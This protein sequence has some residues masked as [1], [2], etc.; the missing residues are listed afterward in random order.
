[1]TRNPALATLSFA[2]R[3]Q[4]VAGYLGQL[5]LL[6]SALTLLPLAVALVDAE[7]R[8][9]IGLAAASL[10]LGVF[11][12]VA[13][14]VDAAVRIQANEALAVTA[15]SYLLTA[16]VMALPMAAQGLAP[17]DALFESVSA[18]TTTG[19][20]T[21]TASE[22]MPRSLL[23]LRAWMQWY[24]G[25]GIVIL[26]VALL[27]GDDAIARRLIDEDL[28]DNL[29]TT[30]RLYARKMLAVYLVLTVTGIAVVTLT[31]LPLFEAICHVLA[32]VSTGGFSTYDQSLAGMANGWQRAAVMALCL[33]GA[34]SLPLYLNLYRRDWR[35]L[36]ENHEIRALVAA[37]LLL[38]VAIL[39]FEGDWRQP[40]PD[41]VGDAFL[42]AV[43]AQTTAGFS[44]APPA[45]LSAATKWAVILA[46]AVGGCVGSTAGGIKLLRLLLAFRLIAG[47]LRRTSL[48]SGAVDEP[49][50][51]G[52]L[53]SK[54]EVVRT[55]L[56]VTLF[57]LG[58][59]F[60]WLPFLAAGHDP[61]N[62]LFDVVSATG[63]VGLST[64]VATAAL[65]PG[66]KAVLCVDML[67]GR[68]EFL[69]LLI[70][71]YPRTWV[72]KRRSSP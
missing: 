17:I 59:L 60:S 12:L 36:R 13:K 68:V 19:L 67:L 62:A 69:A 54:D 65:A 61:L 63:T 46:M 11:G 58:V 3:P 70:L 72:G 27:A 9:A 56:V 38:G 5:M 51:G 39:V 26:S 34:L 37:V 71:L 66:L 57:G 4:V 18:I 31:G 24:G 43:S 44:T 25:L 30:T 28:A 40:T 52:R 22:G 53:I 14:P 45:Q 10:L 21:I 20:S 23:F 48:A 16:G 6:V 64:G 50:L 2:V 7:W 47:A 29:A 49:R 35:H 15:L 1:M 41:S 55:F 32:A 33:V 8:M 42:L